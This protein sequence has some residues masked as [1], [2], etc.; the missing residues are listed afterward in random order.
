MQ[1]I[2]VELLEKEN[3]PTPGVDTMLEALADLQ[4]HL[5]TTDPI[6]ADPLI[7]IALTQCPP[8]LCRELQDIY[9]NKKSKASNAVGMEPPAVKQTRGPAV[10]AAALKTSKPTSAP[11]RPAKT[12]QELDDESGEDSGDEYV[13]EVEKSSHPRKVIKTPAFITEEME[14]DDEEEDEEEEEKPTKKK[15][16]ARVMDGDEAEDDNQPIKELTKEDRH[17]LKVDA[18]WKNPDDEDPLV[19]LLKEQKAMDQGLKTAKDFHVGPFYW[20][21]YTAPL[22]GGP[23]P[24]T[25]EE[26]EDRRINP[27]KGYLR[28]YLLVDV[29]RSP[30]VNCRVTGKTCF[31]GG[32]PPKALGKT[33][34]KERKNSGACAE[35]RVLKRRC[36]DKGRSRFRTIIESPWFQDAKKPVGK[37][38]IEAQTP[39]PRAR[40]AAAVGVAAGGTDATSRGTASLPSSGMFFFLPPVQESNSQL[41]SKWSVSHHPS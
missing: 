22:M 38:K 31:F 28:K 3:V 27:A 35:C 14:D 18:A 2:I 10:P 30:C 16:K 20:G 11:S 7:R 8:S 34:G 39:A 12:Y 21:S 9:A 13:E 41:R 24:I 32:I 1:T 6:R 29:Y 23:T 25:F 17:Q 26:Y 36:D 4:P 40:R 19:R 37:V 33:K 5:K 15:G